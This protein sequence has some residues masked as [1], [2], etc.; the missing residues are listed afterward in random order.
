MGIPSVCTL[1]EKSWDNHDDDCP[2]GIAQKAEL[3]G[4]PEYSRSL[5][6]WNL[7]EGKVLGVRKWKRKT[8][9]GWMIGEITTE[10]NDITIHWSNVP[11][12]KPERLRLWRCEHTASAYTD[13]FGHPHDGYIVNDEVDVTVVERRPAIGMWSRKESPRM[14]A[15]AVDG[16]GF[17]YF[18]NWSGT[19]AD[20][21][22]MPMWIWSDGWEMSTDFFPHVYPD[23]R[24]AS[25]DP[26]TIGLRP[27]VVDRASGPDTAPKVLYWMGQPVEGM[28]R[29]QL[30]EALGVMGDTVEH[31]R[32]HARQ[33]REM[34]EKKR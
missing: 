8:P 34:L 27:V 33:E 32:E 11:Q 18:C 6:T 21:S 7:Y 12:V 15:R 17:Q 14:A 1:C 2:V 28:S 24:K 3:E 30:V 31:M 5:P 19:F 29:E 10:G 4:L 20:D 26:D 25:K 9:D 13:Q 22:P 16:K 23:G